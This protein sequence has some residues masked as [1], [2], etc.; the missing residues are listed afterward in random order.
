[1]TPPGRRQLVLLKSGHAASAL[2]DCRSAGVK[3]SDS[4][5]VQP[6]APCWI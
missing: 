4:G 3:Q 1:M 6:T 2:A 5:L